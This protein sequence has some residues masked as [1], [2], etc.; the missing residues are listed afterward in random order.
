M[1]EELIMCGIVGYIGAGTAQS[2]LL[3]CIRK[4]STAGDCP[5]TCLTTM[6]SENMGN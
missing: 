2:I 6:I 4:W 5:K 1:V 3:K